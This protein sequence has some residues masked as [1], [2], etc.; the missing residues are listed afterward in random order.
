MSVTSG[1]SERASS[2]ASCSVAG[3]SDDLD[4]VVGCEQHFD[5]LDEE[6]LVVGYEHA[7]APRAAGVRC[8]FH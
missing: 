1:W 2:T 3:G 5:R 7:D 8:G 6:R 4:A